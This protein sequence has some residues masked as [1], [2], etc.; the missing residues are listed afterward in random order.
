MVDPESDAVVG[1]GWSVV[2]LGSGHFDRLMRHF[3]RLVECDCSSGLPRRST[4]ATPKLGRLPSFLL[5]AKWPLS[6]KSSPQP[7]PRELANSSGGSALRLWC[8]TPFPLARCVLSTPN[9]AHRILNRSKQCKL[10][11]TFSCTSCPPEQVGRACFGEQ[12]ATFCQAPGGMRVA[13]SQC[14][15]L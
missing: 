15:C 9:V 13:V 6:T 14:A 1:G 11:P 12:T 10:R 2:W 7:A 3:D 8:P 5:A 4:V